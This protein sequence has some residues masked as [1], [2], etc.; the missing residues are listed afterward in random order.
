MIGA[1]A[2]KREVGL[3]THFI[4]CSIFP[5]FIKIANV[6][7]KKAKYY[8]FYY[9]HEL[10][11]V[12]E[13]IDVEDFYGVNLQKYVAEI[14]EG[15]TIDSR[16]FCRFFGGQLTRVRLVATDAGKGVDDFEENIWNN[17]FL[18]EKALEK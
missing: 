3:S 8:S 9:D 2:L 16:R 15:K 13:L 11:P 18:L 5:E 17:P 7:Y 1:E 10:F 4:A 14:G 6:R 12:I